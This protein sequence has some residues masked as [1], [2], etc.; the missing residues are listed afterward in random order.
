MSD[1]VLPRSVLSS[2]FR[3]RARVAAVAAAAGGA[4]GLAGLWPRIEDGL[5]LRLTMAGTS[6][7]FAAVVL[8]VALC[9]KTSS[10][11]VGRAIGLSSVLGFAS[12]ILPSVMLKAEDPTIPTAAFFVASLFCGPVIGFMYGLVLAALAGMTW[13]DVNAWTHDG[14]DRATRDAALWAFFPALIVL[15]MALGHDTQDLSQWASE[16]DRAAHAVAAPLG[17]FGFAMVLGTIIIAFFSSQLRLSRRRRFIDA[18]LAG[19]DPAWS[20]RELGP[21]DDLDALPRLRDGRHVLEY[22]GV[23]GAYRIAAVGRAIAIL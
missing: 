19:G 3:A 6:A 22:R 13:R 16:S 17:V 11:A 12:A 10:G 21:H 23:A 5:V 2:P 1:A 7:V 4:C 18:A 8:V 15:A 20:L 9:A 14:T